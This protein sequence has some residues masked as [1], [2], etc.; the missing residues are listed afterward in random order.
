M[1][2]TAKTIIR[3][4]G[5]IK[6]N[7][8]ENANEKLLALLDKIRSGKRLT[9]D[10]AE[11]LGSMSA[12]AKQDALGNGES[13]GANLSGPTHEY[14]PDGSAKKV[15][16][17]EIDDPGS[18]P[19][20]LP[21]SSQ[22][23]SYTKYA[24]DSHLHKL[25]ANP[26]FAR[27]AGLIKLVKNNY[28]NLHGQDNPEFADKILAAMTEGKNKD[29]SF[30][31]A[32]RD[33]TKEIMDVVG[34]DKVRDVLK[35]L[36]DSYNSE[37]FGRIKKV[38]QYL[39]HKDQY[40]ESRLASAEEKVAKA[41]QNGTEDEEA[42]AKAAKQFANGSAGDEL[43]R[44]TAGGQDIDKALKSL[45]A[46]A[47]TAFAKG[48][49]HLKAQL[50]TLE[51]AQQADHDKQ[52]WLDYFKEHPDTTFKNMANGNTANRGLL[53][54][55]AFN[56][57]NP[58]GKAFPLVKHGDVRN[59]LDALAESG[60]KIPETEFT[61]LSTKNTDA[62]DDIQR[63]QK[64]IDRYNNMFR[65]GD[66]R[67]VFQDKTLNKITD[68]DDNGFVTERTRDPHHAYPNIRTS[69]TSMYKV[70]ARMF[71]DYDTD[72]LSDFAGEGIISDGSP[73]SGTAKLLMDKWGD[74]HPRQ[75]FRDVV[76]Y[77]N[78]I[79]NDVLGDDKGIITPEYLRSLSKKFKDIRGLNKGKLLMDA[80][81][82]G[83]IGDVFGKIH[84]KMDPSQ[85]LNLLKAFDS[86]NRYK[87]SSAGGLNLPAL[88]EDLDTNILAIKN[89]INSS[90][91]AGLEDKVPQDKASGILEA[92]ENV[93]KLISTNKEKEAMAKELTGGKKATEL[94]DMQ[95]LAEKYPDEYNDLISD[96]ADATSEYK[97]AKDSHA[98]FDIV[99]ILR[100][101]VHDLINQKSR[102]ETFK[103]P[104]YQES[105]STGVPYHELLDKYNQES[106][107]D[108][109]NNLLAE[110][111]VQQ[112]LKDLA[113]GKKLGNSAV[114]AEVLS[115]M[116]DKVADIDPRLADWRDKLM[117]W[118]RPL[119]T[120][121]LTDSQ[122]VAKELLNWTPEMFSA[123]HNNEGLFNTDKADVAHNRVNY[124]QGKSRSGVAGADRDAA[125]DF[126]KNYEAAKYV[127]DADKVSDME[128]SAAAENA[129]AKDSYTLHDKTKDRLNDA[130]ETLK[131]LL[132]ALSK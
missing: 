53:M 114:K 45:Y 18:H 56:E 26:K 132:N 12:Q 92:L 9:I 104:I 70:L 103:A 50:K 83:N 72:A 119:S 58:N 116:L 126:I 63:N 19:Q 95:T 27:D 120:K 107:E 44:I 15:E 30:T 51:R 3:N 54:L 64:W 78:Y 97:L 13:T 96:L 123:Y 69:P 59:F 110:F 43:S 39:T 81:K 34:K 113:G 128:G 31:E 131:N 122:N 101:K 125:D 60:F 61:N 62:T 100:D 111:D 106:D 37:T 117:N 32:M 67:Y 40:A 11:F 71:K 73:L 20:G 127:N 38:M 86:L 99:N 66:A 124:G 85:R 24:E 22:G 6:E 121:Y 65:T 98:D 42:R 105:E 57:A 102:F 76:N 91:F 68:R 10:E 17:H 36:Q 4:Q 33:Y 130:G 23:V 16:A 28:N 46:N 47:S 84:S 8:Q 89:A 55:T 7:V 93:R 90:D 1:S 115:E 5:E 82:G 87:L 75:L 25:F 29:L 48:G 14:K 2:G 109:I 77:S 108:Y 118:S 129:G 79:G 35:G 41:M 21:N 49:D 80:I 74:D 52:F 112:S 88:R 94:N